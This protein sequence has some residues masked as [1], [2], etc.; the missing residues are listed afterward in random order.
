MPTRELRPELGTV[1]TKDPGIILIV[2]IRNT[3]DHALRRHEALELAQ[4]LTRDLILFRTIVPLDLRS[5]QRLFR[6]HQLCGPESTPFR[7]PTFARR[8]L[9]WFGTSSRR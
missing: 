7:D 9:R 1:R 4:A 8:P 2:R 6:K 3:H 5:V